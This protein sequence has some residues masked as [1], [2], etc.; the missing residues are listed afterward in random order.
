MT[1]IVTADIGGTH[2][3]FALADVAGGRV[4]SLDAPVTYRTADHAGLDHA[5]R[6]FGEGRALPPAAAIAVAG[7]V[8][9]ETLKLTNNPW[10]ICPAQLPVALGVERL[11]LVNDF[12]AVAHAVAQLGPER[13]DHVC[14]P[15]R[16]LPDRGV[17]SVLG[18]GTGLGV[19]HVLRLADRYVVTETEGGHTDFAPLDE[20]EDR[21]LH[22][23]R[24]R[25]RRVSTE[26][27][28]AGPGL[29]AIHAT[30]AMIEGEA[31]VPRPDAELWT[32]ALAGEDRLATAALERF[33]MILGAVAGDVAL[34][35][36]ASAVVIA[37]GVGL[38][39]AGRL[40]RSGFPR[41]FAAKGRFEAL[42]RRVPVRLVTH[43]QP[44]LYGAAAAFA[45]EHGDT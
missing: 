6:A 9:G 25:H 33:C 35:Q 24:E 27:V 16:T 40:A 29:V 41:R 7:P 15:D 3:R 11:A 1:R 43:D 2:A 13:F 20:I 31:I 17:I 4:V 39:L 18:P 8:T 26:R 22:V 28:A 45:Q 44:G 21:I 19:A 10:A 42:M 36:G 32:A 23:L 5:W 14:G 37:G 30:L 38:R 12:G 34:A